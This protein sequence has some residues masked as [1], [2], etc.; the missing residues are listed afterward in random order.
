LPRAEPR[1]FES[2]LRSLLS[3]SGARAPAQHSSSRGDPGRSS[4]GRFSHPADPRGVPRSAKTPVAP[5]IKT[6]IAGGC[7]GCL[8]LPWGSS[9]WCSSR[10]RAQISYRRARLKTCLRNAT[11][12]YLQ[13]TG[14][15]S[16]VHASVP[17]PRKA[18]RLRWRTR[19]W[20][21]CSCLF[22]RPDWSKAT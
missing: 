3:S 20:T 10:G 17:T 2:A 19:R 14:D 13:V 8:R 18:Q 12:K 1:C 21:S 6:A 22:I 9:V 4:T 15:A 11:S 16:V 5:V 7:S